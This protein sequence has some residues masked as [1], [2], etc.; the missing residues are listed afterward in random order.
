MR[1]TSDRRGETVG[2]FTGRVWE[3]AHDVI[4]ITDQGR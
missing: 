1:L 4:Q 3:K 2:H